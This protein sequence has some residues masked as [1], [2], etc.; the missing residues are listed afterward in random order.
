MTENELRN[1]V[2]ARARA[3]IGRREA[4]GSHR[5]IIDLYN[6]YRLPG[7]AAM[8][9]RDPWCAAFVSAVGMDCGL[10]D[11]ILPHINCDGMIAAYRRGGRWIENDAYTPKQGDLIF[12]DWQDDGIGDNTGSADHV[13]IVVGVDGRLIT[14]I[15]GNYSNAVGQR[16]IYVD[17]KFIRG[18]AVPDYAS[19]VRAGNTDGSVGAAIQDKPDSYTVQRGD[20][21]SGIAAKFGTTV[22]S[23]SAANGIQDP[24]KIQVGQVIKLAGTAPETPPEASTATLTIGEVQGRTYTVKSGD[25]LWSIGKRHGVGWSAI[26]KAN[27]IRFPYIIRPGQLLQIPGEE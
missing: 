14:V 7:T 18:Y 13:G 19:K 22:A 12:Y 27:G 8:S 11:V 9:Y 17:G 26:A 24:D 20:T 3:W 4:D 6:K 23:L 2:C 5:E 25:S 21:L 1:K 15:E 10:R 16:Y